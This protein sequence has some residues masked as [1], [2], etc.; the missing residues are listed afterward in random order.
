M[1]S[2][3]LFAMAGGV[4]YLV[5]AGVLLLTAP[6][7]GP[8]F[9]RILSFCSAVLA[10]WLMNRALAFRHQRSGLSLWRE[11]LR[12]FA[13]CLGGG[14]VNLAVYSLLVFLFDWS[15][16]WLLVAVGVGSLA[17]MGV[18]FVLSKRFVFRRSPAAKS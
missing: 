10:T 15:G 18:N 3:L 16:W 5:D 1:R 6:Y 7:A 12:Y 2:L 4:G 9:G 17:G 13:V 8:Y 11:F 14:S